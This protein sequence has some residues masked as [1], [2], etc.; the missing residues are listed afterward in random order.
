MKKGKFLLETILVMGGAIG[1]YKV[2][3]KKNI[4]ALHEKY[5]F[6]QEF[7]DKD[8]RRM[9]QCMFT[10]IGFKFTNWIMCKGKG[11]MVQGVKR[12]LYKIDSCDNKK[13]SLYIYEPEGSEKQI[14]PCLVYFHG[15]AFYGDYFSSYHEILEKYAKYANCRVVSV[16]YRTLSDVT[17]RTSLMDCYQGLIWSFNNADKLYIDKEH[18]AV[19][20]DSAGGTFAAAITHL[21]RELSGPKLCYQMLLYPATD[22]SLHS[23]SMRK[24]TDTP[25][26]NA[27]NHKKLYEHIL[28]NLS[29]DIRSYLSLVE[30]VSFKGLCDAYVE[31]EEM[32]CLHD[33]G[34][35]YANLLISNGYKVYF[36]DVKGTFHAFEQNQN[37]NISKKIMK[38]RCEMLK[39]AFE[40]KD[41]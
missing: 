20:G 27:T 34:V 30:Q 5:N 4:D 37:L 11:K 17:F 41:V 23:E 32:D 9:P 40:D 16:R 15:G 33:D 19:G 22:T 36:N 3:N 2:N 12:S 31:V 35:K 6:L 39:N 14:L 18:I 13:I 7:T 10:P 1:A 38:V 8:L 29:E 24:Y 25:G 26:W 21:V 28:P